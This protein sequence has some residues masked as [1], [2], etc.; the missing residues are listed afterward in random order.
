MPSETDAAFEALATLNRKLLEA[1]AQP[2][3]RDGS[4]VGT[5]ELMQSLAASV[6][7]DPGRWL[8]L[9]NR[10]YGRQLDL[11]SALARPP[12]DPAPQP[13]GAEVRPDPRFRAAEWREPYFDYVSRSYLLASQ[14]LNEVLAGVELEPQARRKLT[15]YARQYMDAMSPA[16]FP[17]S[18]PEALKLASETGGESLARG[19]QNLAGDLE[20]GLVS[21]TD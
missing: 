12:A 16:N 1:I 17:W 18:N 7:H 10:Y 19:M 8:E 4:V 9:Q 11:W 3:S 14:W 20:K 2:L 21:M 15:F 6:A 5:A 13:A